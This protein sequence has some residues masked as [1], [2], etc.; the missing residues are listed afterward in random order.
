MCARRY[1]GQLTSMIE[2]TRH[3][4]DK[5][6]ADEQPEGRKAQ[7]VAKAEASEMHQRVLVLEQQQC[8]A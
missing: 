2:T 3:V 1:V 5:L 8:V 7:Q 4:V 6:V